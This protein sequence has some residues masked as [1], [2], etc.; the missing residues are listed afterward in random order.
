MIGYGD[1]FV[2]YEYQI[3]H[4]DRHYVKM[5]DMEDVVS[6]QCEEDST[7]YPRPISVKFH[8]EE[9]YDMAKSS[10]ANRTGLLF[11]VHDQSCGSLDE[12]A[13]Y[14]ADELTFGDDQYLVRIMGTP[15]PHLK[16]ES[17]SKVGMS[18]RWMQ[19]AD[20]THLKPR[21]FGADSNTSESSGSLEKRFDF[22]DRLEKNPF[23]PGYF[24]TIVEVGKKGVHAVKHFFDAIKTLKNHNW[25][26]PLPLTYHTDWAPRRRIFE[27]L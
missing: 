14:H 13:I 27:M 24:K 8:H 6:I 16:P 15:L 18:F 2:H 23:A 12:R 11:V 22:R 7:T 3:H 10:W 21:Y 20:A 4:K 26:E 1:R 9:D 17:A 19:T 25:D 5:E